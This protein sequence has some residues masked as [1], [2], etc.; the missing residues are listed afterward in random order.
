MKDLCIQ[1]G[2]K[3]KLSMAHHPQI[4]RQT[5]HMNWDLQQYL[6]LF[7]AK[8]QHEWV[9]WLPLTQLSYNTNQQASTKKSPFEVMHSY[10]PRMGIKSHILKALAANWLADKIAKTLENIK[11]NLEKAQDHI[12]AQAD[13]KCSEAPAYAVGDLIWLSTDNL[14]LSC[15]SKK[16]SEHWL[17]PYKITKKLVLTQ[18]S[19]FCQSLCA[20]ILLLI[21]FE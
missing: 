11:N 2:I 19:C 14:C 13:K 18:L 5:E 21:Y 4:N 15:A 10:A 8:W 20:S 16:L 1:L 7:T 12:K 3:P 17:S 6:W 9:D